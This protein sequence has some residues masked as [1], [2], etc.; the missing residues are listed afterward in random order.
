MNKAS[1]WAADKHA[2]DANEA[3][4]RIEL[5]AEFQR[6]ENSRPRF[7]TFAVVDDNGQ[8]EIKA[9]FATKLDANK[10]LEFAAWIKD[11]FGV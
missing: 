9:S 11:T 5:N 2:L 8:L 1:N 6:V 7:E 4:F 10:A 3:K